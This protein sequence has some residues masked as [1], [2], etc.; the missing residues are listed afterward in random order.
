M[1]FHG[2]VA[3]GSQHE[4]FLKRWISAALDN[5]RT[6]TNFSE[7]EPLQAKQSH[8]V[9]AMHA[10]EVKLFPRTAFDFFTAARCS[11]AGF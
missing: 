10:R 2:R 6:R 1:R 8:A 7:V 3:R 5:Y 4:T 11:L 9:F